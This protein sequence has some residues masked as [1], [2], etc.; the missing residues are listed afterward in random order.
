MAMVLVVDDEFGVASL[1]E[2]VLTDEGHSVVIASN[3]RQ[4]LERVAAQRPDIILTDF[5]MP[6][7]DGAALIN[8]L[9]ADENTAQIPVVVM[10]SLPEAAIAER[11][12]GYAVV[13]RK[14]FKIFSFIKIIDDLI[15]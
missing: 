12:R 3:G 9:K 4:A 15:I 5:M 2:D 13:V 10:S 6:I 1:L 8:A 14:P 11:C 7:M